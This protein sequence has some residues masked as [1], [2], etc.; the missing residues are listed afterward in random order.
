MAESTNGHVNTK[1]ADHISP[2][3]DARGSDAD[4]ESQNPQTENGR[5]SEKVSTFKS[6]GWLDRLLALWILLSMIVGVLLGNFVPETGPALQ[7]G[8]FVGV[9]APIGM[10]AITPRVPSRRS[11]PPLDLL[12]RR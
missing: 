6:L 5:H 10:S 1:D 3:N 7:K 11:K 2:D 4:P 12:R 8:K 9:S